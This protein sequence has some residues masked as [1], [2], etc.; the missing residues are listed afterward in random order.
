[1]WLYIDDIPLNLGQFSTTLKRFPL[2]IQ[3]FQW[4]ESRVNTQFT[5]HCELLLESLHSNLAP[6]GMWGKL[7][8]LITGYM[9]VMGKGEGLSTS[10]T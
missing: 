2:K 8:V 5:H 3:F 4:E 9:I 1:M 7:K 6:Q 10:S